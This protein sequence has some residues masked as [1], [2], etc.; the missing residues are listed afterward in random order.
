MH[1]EDHGLRLR[2]EPKRAVVCG[3]PYRDDEQGRYLSG[4]VSK[5]LRF[6]VITTSL[7]QHERDGV[8]ISRDTA[9]RVDA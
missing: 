4:S 7:E 3:L 1:H 6:S 5:V 8:E 2:R 9:E